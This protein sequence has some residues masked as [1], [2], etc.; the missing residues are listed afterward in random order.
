MLGRQLVAI[1]AAAFLGSAQAGANS[2][3][4]GTR[5]PSTLT[6]TGFFAAGGS[7]ADIYTFTIGAQYGVLATGAAGYP[8]AGAGNVRDQAQYRGAVGTG[9][10]RS[11]V[12][13]SIGGA[14]DYST[15]LAASTR[16]VRDAEHADG[17]AGG[18]DKFPMIAIPEPPDWTMLF[19]GLVVV[20]FMA[21]RKASLV[22][23]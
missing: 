17:Q 23:T 16:P 18:A 20:G 14:I 6:Q 9:P 1:A 19:A 7:F 11:A 5:L 15:L 8:A 22:T 3:E 2:S 12:A 21:R 4:L 10:A 13:S